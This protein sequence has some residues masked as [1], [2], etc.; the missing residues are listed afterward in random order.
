M[1][2]GVRGP[3]QTTSLGGH[4][5]FVTFIDDKSRFTAIYF[6][7]RKYEV[8]QKFKEFEAMAT[9]ITGQKIKYLRSDNGGEYS[10]KEFNYFLTL[11]D[12]SKQRSV[13]RT[14]EQ[15]GVAERMNRTIQETSRSMLH[16]AKLPNDFGGE[17]VATA[18]ILRNRSP[19]KAVKDMTPYESFYGRK[20]DVA[21]LKV[22][23]HPKRAH[24]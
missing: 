22:F 13:P 2:S 7:K 12:I 21:H 9:N 4:Q 3:M 1:H 18:V 8:L 15:N 16:A 24:K 10:S 19:T 6:V 17:A 14:P 11:K 5:Y 23:G 20:P